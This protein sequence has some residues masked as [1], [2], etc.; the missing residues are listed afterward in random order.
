MKRSRERGTL[1]DTSFGD[2]P[3]TPLF[4]ETVPSIVC[5]VAALG[6]ERGKNMKTIQISSVLRGLRL[7]LRA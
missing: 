3:E 5:R 2:L 4:G 7:P 1:P 6:E